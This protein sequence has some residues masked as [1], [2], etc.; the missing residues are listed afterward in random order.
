MA[1]FPAGAGCAAAVLALAGLVFLG[2]CSS[3]LMDL[4]GGP[5]G[6]AGEGPEPAGGSASGFLDVTVRMN[7]EVISYPDQGAVLD[8]EHS[9]TLVPLNITLTR[10]GLDVSWNQSTQQATCVNGDYRL[11][12]TYN[13]TRLIRKQRRWW[14]WE[15]EE[16][17][18]GSRTQIIN[19]RMMVPVHALGDYTP[20]ISA[21]W[22]KNTWTVNLRYWDEPD[23]GLTWVGTGGP[24]W[25][26]FQEWTPGEPNP[27][28]DPNKPTVIFVH[29]W[30]N[31]SVAKKFEPS[32]RLETPNGVDEWTHHA[33]LEQGWNVGI[34]H[35]TSYADEPFVWDA[36]SKM[37]DAAYGDQQ[38]QWKE[39]AGSCHREDMLGSGVGTVFYQKYVQALEHQNPNQEI[40]LVGHSLGTQ[41]VTRLAREIVGRY[42][43][44]HRLSPNRLVLM[45]PAAGTEDESFL[46]PYNRIYNGRDAACSTAEIVASYG[47][48]LADRGMPIEFYRTSALMAA[49]GSSYN[50]P[51]AETS[52]YTEMKPWY[53]QNPGEKH[54]WP[55]RVYFWSLAED[56][57]GECLPDGQGGWTGTGRAAMSAATPAWR[58][59]QMMGGDWKWVQ[60]HGK[61]TE[62]PADDWFERQDF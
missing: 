37:W 10:A 18:L 17:T 8:T 46:R 62:D 34:F 27:Y 4:P 53:T 51:M 19:N 47:E 58:I 5:E 39:S 60:S 28:Y 29:G 13:S 12:F 57:P 55:A 14:G 42:G 43:T 61:T 44:N 2:G 11:I 7:G 32:L 40:R 31:G 9:R 3:P 20:M 6:A 49:P 33:W 38:M 21:W 50:M 30:Q 52:A 59:R 16:F 22:D 56:A 23:M 24:W 15:T 26:N 25:Y 41:L 45:D 35:W 48:S 36:E 54:S 1:V